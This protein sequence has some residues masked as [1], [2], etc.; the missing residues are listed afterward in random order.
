VSQDLSR[1]RD[2]RRV[3]LEAERKERGKSSRTDFRNVRL[4]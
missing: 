4:G 2:G 3:E 1:V